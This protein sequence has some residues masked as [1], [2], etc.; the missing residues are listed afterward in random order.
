MEKLELRAVLRTTTTGP[1][2][3]MIF[4]L[5]PNNTK[6][7][8]IQVHVEDDAALDVVVG[9][10]CQFPIY[11]R[12]EHREEVLKEL[13]QVVEA[14][15][16]GN[17]REDLWMV[18]GEVVKVRGLVDL[19]DRRVRVVHLPLGWYRGVLRRTRVA[20]KAYAAY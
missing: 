14:V 15:V 8:R 17:Y 18:R 13:R 2:S 20:H 10:D 9:G 16:D 1:T 19:P 5:E 7:A 3:E 6:A 11:D 12:P 4:S